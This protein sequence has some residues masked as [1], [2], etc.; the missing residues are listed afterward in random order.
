MDLKGQIE[1]ATEARTEKSE[2]KAKALQAA[3][4]AKGDLTDTSTTRDDDSKYL[5]DL[6]SECSQK[7]SD[8]EM[9][10]Q[11]RAEEITAVEK[12]I[13][14]LSSGAVAGASEKHLPQLLQAQALAQLRAVQH[15]PAQLRV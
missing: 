10:Q 12:A 5:S 4:D 6:S 7:S 15:T 13:E 2:S 9:R 3:A 1:A 14:I 8:F 11:L